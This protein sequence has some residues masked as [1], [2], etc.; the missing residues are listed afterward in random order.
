MERKL[1]AVFASGSGTTFDAILSHS[2]LEDSSYRVSALVT[3]RNSCGAVR[4]ANE[5][6]IPVIHYGNSIIELLEKAGIEII[7]LAGFLK[8]LSP[9]IVRG[10]RNRIIN[11]HPSLLPA[12]G[13][14]GFYGINVHRAVIDSGAMYSGFTVHLV[15]EEVDSGPIVF[16]NAVPVLLSD[17]PEDLE[18]RV[19]AKELEY[20]PRIIDSLCRWPYRIDSKRVIMKHFQN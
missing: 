20:F 13:G 14:K 3:N 1:V 12:F 11:I 2:F 4:I 17:R 19:H 9:D 15:N 10:F 8:I 16:Q 6:S 7:V 18:A 5:H